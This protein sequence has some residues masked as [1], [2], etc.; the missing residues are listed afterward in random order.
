MY[1]ESRLEDAFDS[2]ILDNPLPSS[3][4]RVCQHPCDERCRRQ[5]MDESV[6]MRE[7]H[8]YIADS[9]LLSDRFEAA[10]KRVSRAH[11]GTHWPEDRDGRCWTAGL[12]AAFYLALLGHD[13]TVYDPLPEA[14][15]HAALCTAGVSAAQTGSAA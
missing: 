1:K 9:I 12:T 10:V 11:A 5:T 8:R 4:G 15:R 3:T 6:N 14:G 7:V 13:V 2:I